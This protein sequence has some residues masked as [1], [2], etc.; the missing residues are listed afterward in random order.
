MKFEYYL[1]GYVTSLS[2]FTFFG[3]MFWSS[4]A[5]KT[6]KYKLIIIVT[7]VIY[8]VATCLLA[9][10]VLTAENMYT[11]RLVYNCVFFAASNFFLSASFPLVDAMVLGMLTKNPK[12][13]KE[14]MGN[15]RLFSAFG[16]YASTLITLFLYGYMDNDKKLFNETIGQ[17]SFAQIA[18][19]LIVL[20]LFVVIV[21]FGIA[22]VQPIK[23]G[24]HGHHASSDNKDASGAANAI[25]SSRSP[26]IRLLTNPSFL[27]FT[28]FVF[29][30]GLVNQVTHNYQKIVVND[31]FH[32]S[33]LMTALVDVSRTI[34]E[35]FVYYFSKQFRAFMGVYWVLV[36]SQIAG[37]LR[38]GLYWILGYVTNESA[39]KT[40]CF[41]IELLKGLN[42]GLLSSSAI[43]IASN[44]APAGC[45]SSA[46][47]IYS[48]VYK[49]FGAAFGGIISGGI[50][51]FL[52]CSKSDERTQV[53]KAQT[54]E[55]KRIEEVYGK[56]PETKNMKNA[57]KKEAYKAKSKLD[58]QDVRTVF[59]LVS[60]T[61]IAVTV[62]LSCKF[63]FIDRV[64]GIP[65]FPRRH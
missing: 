18:I 11:W 53:K 40:S 42:S 58:Q 8:T 21:I 48:G 22:D 23:G 12:V 30:A 47:G 43:M 1:Y 29:C 10:E 57:A 20:A 49:G 32:G 2:L 31:V 61:S 36:F 9:I 35:V 4:L 7:S 63:I 5:D 28:L 25:Q 62:L 37:T 64:M 52:Y 16:H 39:K 14:Q 65:G 33:K 15:Q 60:L 27:F 34:S 6:G 44:L 3:S 54:A 59:M 24:H 46:Q 50:L 45:E 56:Y 17:K 51:H 19:L 38:L 41:I 55:M 13:S 26:T